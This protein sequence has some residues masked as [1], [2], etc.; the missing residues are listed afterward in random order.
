LGPDPD[1]ATYIEKAL[2]D[3]SDGVLERLYPYL[4]VIVDPSGDSLLSA[5]DLRRLA[6]NVNI[7]V[8]HLRI[9]TRIVGVGVGDGE[10]IL[11]P[12]QAGLLFEGAPIGTTNETGRSGTLTVGGRENLRVVITGRHGQAVKIRV[13]S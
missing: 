7:F 12:L 2:Q 11:D 8:P 13:V 3:K 10:Y 6:P 5:G 4:E 9:D 1:R